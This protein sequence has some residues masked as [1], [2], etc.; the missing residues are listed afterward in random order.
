MIALVNTQADGLASGCS[1]P[2]ALK[3]MASIRRLSDTLE[4]A[5]EKPI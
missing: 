4:R 2:L 1:A 5:R 3:K